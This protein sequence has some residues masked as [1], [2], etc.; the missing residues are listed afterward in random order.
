MTYVVDHGGGRAHLVTADF[1]NY[2]PDEPY[3]TFWINIR[4]R[5]RVVK[6]VR[7]EANTKI[8]PR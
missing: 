2:W 1:Y 5:D 4:G 6:T 3:V 7:L 8:R